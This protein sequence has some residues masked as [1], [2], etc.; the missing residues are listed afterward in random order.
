ML[1]GALGTVLM[2]GGGMCL[3][4]ADSAGVGVFEVNDHEVLNPVTS[5]R[6]RLAGAL[7]VRFVGRIRP[8]EAS[9]YSFFGPGVEAVEGT[10]E[11]VILPEGW[12]GDVSYEQTKRAVT[13]RN[14][15]PGHAPAFP[16]VEGF[17]K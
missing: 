5:G 13:L 3:V 12:H 6:V 14:L 11:R 9:V 10:F 8:H 16:G 15:R 7:D 2:G 17:G 1:A 4:A